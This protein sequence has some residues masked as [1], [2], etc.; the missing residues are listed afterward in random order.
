MHYMILRQLLK[1]TIAQIAVV[2]PEL[3][4]SRTLQQQCIDLRASRSLQPSQ[5][6]QVS[7]YLCGI[8]TQELISSSIDAL[9]IS[10]S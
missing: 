4:V 8:W 1:Q 7:E 10:P 6:S 9:H 5:A 3:Y 2:L